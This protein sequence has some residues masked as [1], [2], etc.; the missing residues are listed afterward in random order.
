MLVSFWFDD[1]AKARAGTKTFVVNAIGDAGLL[2]GILLLF[3]AMAAAGVEPGAGAFNFETLEAHSM[4]MVPIA[5]LASLLIF[6]GCVGKSAQIPLSVWLPDAMVAP[7]PVSALIHAATMVAAGVYLVVRMNFLVVLSPFAMEIMAITGAA[8]ALIAAVMGLAETDLKRILAYST[9]SQLGLMYLAVG[10]GAFT[11]SIFH[12]VA[13]GFFKALLF[14][15]AGSAIMALGGE[16]DVRN[17]GGL[18]RRMPVTAWGFVIGAAALAGIIPTIGFFSKELILWQSWERGHYFLWVAGFLGS[19]LSALYIFRAVGLAFFGETH[20]P[21]ER[22][23][24]A[25]EPVFS[26]IVPIMLL[27]TAVMLGGLLGVPASFGGEERLITWLGALIPTELSHAPTESSRGTEI[28]LAAATLLWSA[29][30][31]VL[32][33]LVYAQRRDW[34][35]RMALRMGWAA[36]LVARR[37]Y[38]DE[39]YDRALVRPLFWIGRHVLRRWIDEGVLGGVV[40]SGS[41]RAVGF[42]AE[43][44]SAAESGVL[45]HYLVMAL[46]GAVILIALLT[47]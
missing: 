46:V 44:A 19:G 12:L 5:T 3:G 45:Q 15:A 2:L 7:T 13:H 32:G 4:A 38:L 20:V 21:I 40:I 36:R 24:K 34:A 29:H 22:F 33:W 31:A 16:Q 37:F 28:V 43:A 39:F 41:G 8:S 27:S 30:F 6:A 18:A 11:A 26:M 42:A 35:R 14:L 9:I 1:A 23:K 17:M 47:L 10:L 25:T